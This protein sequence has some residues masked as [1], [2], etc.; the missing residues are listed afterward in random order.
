MVLWNAGSWTVEDWWS[1]CDNIRDGW[2][3]YCTGKISYNGKVLP[4]AN[5]Y[6]FCWLACLHESKDKKILLKGL[7]V[8]LWNFKLL[9]GFM[10]SFQFRKCFFVLFCFCIFWTFSKQDH[11]II[12]WYEMRRTKRI[13]LTKSSNKKWLNVFIEFRLLVSE[14]NTS[15]LHRMCSRLACMYVLSSKGQH[16][17]LRAVQLW[18]KQVI[19]KLLLTISDK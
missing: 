7:E 6:S 2:L 11:K 15:S 1:H 9:N 5:F 19:D 10:C 18:V 16:Q 3:T 14:I 8:F 12:L 17:G 4:G 13:E